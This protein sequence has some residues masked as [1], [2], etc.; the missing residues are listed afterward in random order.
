[1]RGIRCNFNDLPN[2]I[3]DW[4]NEEFISV[5]WDI[6][7]LREFPTIELIQNELEIN[8]DNTIGGAQ[9]LILFRDLQIGTRI[10]THHPETGEFHSGTITNAYFYQESDNLHNHRRMIEWDGPVPMNLFDQNL[11][12][13]RIK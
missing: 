7:D 13:F 5:A 4:L 9:Q 8:N 1:M 3:N 12:D 11:G 6:A 10:L 2:L